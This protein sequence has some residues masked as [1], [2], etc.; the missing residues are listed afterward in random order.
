MWR[1]EDDL[2][3]S[4]LSSDHMSPKTQTQ[5]LRLDNKDFSFLDEPSHPSPW[6]AFDL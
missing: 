2:W 3:E 5:I 4:F 1:S 6:R